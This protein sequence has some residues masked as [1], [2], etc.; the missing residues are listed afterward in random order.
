MSD[1][2]TIDR[3]RESSRRC[4]ERH[5]LK[6][7]LHQE[8]GEERETDVSDAAA[9]RAIGRSPRE[10]PPKFY[11]DWKEH[12][13]QLQVLLD[14][15]DVLIA[16][17]KRASN[18]QLW[19]EDLYDR[20]HGEEWRVFPFLHT[21]PATDPDKMEWVDTN[22]AKCPKTSALLKKLPGIRTALYSRMA[23]KMKL[24]PH[25]GW[26]ALSNHVLR[27]H[28]SLILPE[29]ENTSGVWM[30]GEKR[31]HR[32]GDILVFDDSQ[33]HSGFNLSE[34]KRCVLIVDILRP[35][36]VPFGVATG[37]MTTELQNY[38]EYF[39]KEIAGK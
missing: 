20:K 33:L 25:R 16:E 14:N 2:E 15:I 27:C 21:F 3:V 12:F 13:P 35:K 30:R 9:H 23:P 7:K 29:E 8:N 22:C 31:Y 34:S 24:T 10:Y 4:A 5:D 19:P 36:S 37:K 38:I 6:K 32:H 1:E 17:M 28:I 39:K 26:A 11:D 18:W